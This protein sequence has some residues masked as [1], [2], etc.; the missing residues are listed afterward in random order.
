MG[1]LYSEVDKSMIYK[2]WL[3]I[4]EISNSKKIKLLCI[5][6]NESRIYENYEEISGTNTKYDKREMLLRAEKILFWMQ[7]NNINIITIGEEIYPEILRQ[8]DEPP[9][10]L[11]YK[12]KINLLA[13]RIVAI[14]GSRNCSNYGVEV[15]KLLTKE[16][17]SYN[18]TII[19]GGAKGIDTVAHKTTL[20]TNGRT[21][22][23]LGCGI[24]VAYPAQNSTLFKKIEETGLI[25][26]EFPPGTKPFSY[27][28]PRRNR[29]ISGLSEA[30]IVAEA[31]EKSGSLITAN[32]AADQGKEVMVVPGSIF[33]KGCKGCNMLIKDGASVISSLEDLRN[34]LGLSKSD[35]ISLLSPVKEKILSIINQ[36]PVHID[37][38]VNKSYIDREELFKVL[39][40]MRIGK[41][42]VFLPG[43][44]YAR[45][46]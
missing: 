3:L 38:I 5:Y 37:E 26:S 46:I 22:V 16:L 30:V 34:E 39:F 27:N 41:E 40:E 33:L 36:E 29:I 31:A 14:I 28:F 32:F 1:K 17:N 8:I 2:L 11:F 12:G 9:Y 15:T 35:N 24:D 6:G 23:V 43:D 10:G 45:I 4:L 21:I 42:I 18:I 19:S 44:Y 25:L 7:E 20:E 13:D